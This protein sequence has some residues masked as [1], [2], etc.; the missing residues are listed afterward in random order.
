MS[1]NWDKLR[2]Y[3]PSWNIEAFNAVHHIGDIV[4]KETEPTRS[5]IMEYG[6]DETYAGITVYADN[7]N[8]IMYVWMSQYVKAKKW[9]K[10]LHKTDDKQE[11]ATMI[12]Q[13]FART[14]KIDIRPWEVEPVLEGQE[15]EDFEWLFMYELADINLYEQ[16]YPKTEYAQIFQEREER[17]QLEARKAAIG[18]CP[19][20]GWMTKADVC[21]RCGKS[22]LTD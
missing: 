7:I 12:Y 2:K 21:P 3:K 4:F 8:M 16:F 9:V 15:T 5:V 18:K 20:C 14:L 22:T 19:H 6:D 10:K 17:K 11:F 1:I 13:Q